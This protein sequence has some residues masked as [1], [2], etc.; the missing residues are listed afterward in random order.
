MGFR[1]FL[2]EKYPEIAVLVEKEEA[3]SCPQI[4][5]FLEYID[6]TNVPDISGVDFPEDQEVLVE[7]KHFASFT[8]ENANY[9]GGVVFRL[10]SVVGDISF[11]GS[12]VGK[13]FELEGINC[14]DLMYPENLES[15]KVKLT[16]IA[17]W[18]EI[19]LPKLS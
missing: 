14:K 10:V 19:S 13:K 3:V 2:A 1:D 9:N 11:G 5:D 18:G 7:K 15:S 17:S 12:C 16:D 8:A 4:G 6:N